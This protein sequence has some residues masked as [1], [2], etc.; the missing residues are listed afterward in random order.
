MQE[1]VEK[2]VFFVATSLHQLEFFGKNFPGKSCGV[3]VN[4]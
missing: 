4:P 2:G 3:R 1:L